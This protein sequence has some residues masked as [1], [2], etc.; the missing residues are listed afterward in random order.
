[1]AS[2]LQRETLCIVAAP[3][4]KAARILIARGH[5]PA[6]MVELWHID[7]AEWTLR[8]KLGAVA[9]VIL[10]G[11]RKAQRCARNSGSVSSAAIASDLYSEAGW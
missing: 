6:S 5:D 9:E 4:V 1:M 7:A 11:E 2:D 3:M 8:G 10:D